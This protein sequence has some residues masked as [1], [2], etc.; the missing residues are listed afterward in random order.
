MELE[1]K[2]REEEVEEEGEHRDGGEEGAWTHYLEDF[3]RSRM[4]TS[5]LDNS[6]KPISVRLELKKSQTNEGFNVLCLHFRKFCTKIRE[7]NDSGYNI[8]ES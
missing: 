4:A 5:Y 7:I 8:A 2:I 1:K 6:A 3:S